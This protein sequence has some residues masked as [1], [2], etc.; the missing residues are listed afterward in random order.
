MSICSAHLLRSRVVLIDFAQN[1]NCSKI[2]H[3][4]IK[5]EVE[6]EVILRISQLYCRSM[7]WAYLILRSYMSRLQ[8]FSLH[9][10]WGASM[11]FWSVSLADQLHSQ[12]HFF[13]VKQKK[14]VPSQR[15]DNFFCP[16]FWFFFPSFLKIGHSRISRLDKKNQESR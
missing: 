5:V 15:S 3:F 8:E 10:I 6:N 11:W 14:I 16:L 2:F 12:F 1:S 7:K 13:L 9:K 4:I